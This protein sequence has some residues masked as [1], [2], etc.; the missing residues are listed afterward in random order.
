[1]I[2][3][4]ASNL[5]R[6]QS[7]DPFHSI[8]GYRSAVIGQQHTFAFP[9]ALPGIAVLSPLLGM[10][11][12]VPVPVA[13]VPLALAVLA[14][15]LVVLLLVVLLDTD[16]GRARR[17]HV[18]GHLAEPALA[19]LGRLLGLTVRLRLVRVVGQGSVAVA[20]TVAAALLACRVVA[21]AVRRV[22]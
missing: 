4:S 10:P 3:Q 22:G 7:L 8:R 15:L 14:V 13:V 16:G 17:R 19:A 18:L 6:L 2:R 20:S 1:M 12:V 21:A 5:D 11:P 9:F